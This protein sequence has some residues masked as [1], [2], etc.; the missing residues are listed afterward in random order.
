MCRLLTLLALSLLLIVLGSGCAE[1]P[2]RSR[3][4]LVGLDGASPRIVREMFQA[5][6]LP[7]LARLADRG[8]L[9]PL[10]SSLPLLSPPIWAS[11]AT[12][13]TRE[14]HGIDAFVK[15]DEKGRFR[16]LLG[17]DRR[18]LALWNIVSDAGRRV[19]VINWWNT[20]PPEVIEGVMVSDHALPGE[21]WR[22][23]L[24]T[25]S[26][27]VPAGALV[28]PQHW[29]E[30][31]G[32]SLAGQI[33]VGWPDPFT[34]ND[35]LPRWGHPERLAEV[36]RDDARAVEIALTVEDE[37]DPDLLMVFMPGIDRVSH[38]LWGCLEED[39]PY[40]DRLTPTPSERRAGAEAVLAYYRYADAL[41]GRLLERFTPDDL[42]MIVSDHGFEAGTT[43]RLD[44]TGLHKTVAA[45]DGI[46]IAAGRGIGRQAPA[47]V[48]TIHDVTP[49]VLAWMEL[50]VGRDMDGRA[51]PFLDAQV[52]WIETHDTRAIERLPTHASGKEEE[53]LRNLRDLGYIE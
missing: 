31:L 8:L 27:A 38:R 4:L 30:R 42:V 28:Y 53:I 21:V 5:G 15:R 32:S 18:T 47:E 45:Q 29:E 12:G 22:R 46:L 34:G 50:P 26:A 1:E 51:A 13:K 16:L 37:I 2:S 25:R 43:R 41:V 36:F 39:F 6:Q 52:T 23:R 24:L 44:L 19:V 35:A 14:K 7:H 11:I 48:V 49:T 20:F 3:V 10:R 9:V 40:P 17:S 33:D